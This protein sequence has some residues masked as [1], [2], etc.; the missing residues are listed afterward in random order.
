MSHKKPHEHKAFSAMI[1]LPQVVKLEYLSWHEVE[2]S[3]LEPR[4][5][6]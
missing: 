4:L 6:V 1:L 5:G 2:I 3:N